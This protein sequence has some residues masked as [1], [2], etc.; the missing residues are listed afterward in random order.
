[1]RSCA[2]G[3]HADDAREPLLGSAPMPGKFSSAIA[4]A[5]VLGLLVP[6][7]AGAPAPCAAAERAR[8]SP[9]VDVRYEPTPHAVVDAMLR[10]AKVGPEDVLIDLG[11][12]DGRIPIAAAATYGA[13][14][15]G[16]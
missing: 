5:A 7:T 13:T 2:A 10:L 3:L 8:P 12:G 4:S 14:A 15:L 11:S 16:V 6:A 1:M 9:Q